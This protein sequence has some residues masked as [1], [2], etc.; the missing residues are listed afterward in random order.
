[1]V[2]GSEEPRNN[3]KMGSQKSP[4]LCA[5]RLEQ[6]HHLLAISGLCNSCVHEAKHERKSKSLSFFPL[7]F[8]YLVAP[9]SSALLPPTHHHI[10]LCLRACSNNPRLVG[11]ALEYFFTSLPLTHIPVFNA[12]SILVFD[13]KLGRALN[14]R[15]DQV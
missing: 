4:P 7:F 13:R 9:L 1:M 10:I 8:S 2:N 12:E 5:N 14:L 15:V 6:S 3:K 11:Y